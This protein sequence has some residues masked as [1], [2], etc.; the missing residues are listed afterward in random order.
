ML[1]LLDASLE[2]FL[3][4]IVPLPERDVA[5]A[6][7][8]PDRDWGQSVTRPTV[9][10]YLWDIRRNVSEAQAGMVVE[11]R[12]DGGPR[13]RP[14]KPR[15]DCRYLISAWTNDVQDEHDLLGL[16]LTALLPQ[17]EIPVDHL[18]GRYAEVR[19]IPTIKLASVDD[20]AKSDFWSALGGQL[21]P[22]LDLLVT[23]TVDNVID[24]EAGPP[25]HRRNLHIADRDEVRIAH[26]RSV[27]GTVE[28]EERKG[29]LVSTRRGN[30]RVSEP[31]EGRPGTFLV[32]G[33]GGD[34]VSV[35]GRSGDEDPIRTTIP[36]EGPITT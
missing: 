10:L 14:Q 32:P 27:G 30:T 28:D 34:D 22:G 25:V 7:D 1:K 8:A 5:I 16:V 20:D 12:D 2:S 15:I 19:P 24:Q 35:D 13:R 3:R 4:A 11:D 23:A 18:E 6:F 26:H 21:K 17:T 33:D 29:V 36:E 31:P 9:N